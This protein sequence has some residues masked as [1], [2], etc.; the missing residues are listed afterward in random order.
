[1][2]CSKTLSKFYSLHTH[3]QYTVDKSKWIRKLSYE[4]KL[5]FKA[6][7]RCK[8]TGNIFLLCIFGFVSVK[9][10][11]CISV[12]PQSIKPDSDTETVGAVKK[13]WPTVLTGIFEKKWKENVAWQ[14]RSWSEDLVGFSHNVIRAAD[15]RADGKELDFTQC[16]N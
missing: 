16:T 6:T 9:D 15:C 11:W 5:F 7:Y 14:L 13:Q 1:M 10:D 2:V 4:K 3:S 8:R 12:L